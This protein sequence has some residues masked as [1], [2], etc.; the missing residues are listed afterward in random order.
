VVGLC[1]VT[2][3][4]LGDGLFD[5]S[6]FQARRGRFGVGSDSNVR[7]DAAGELCLLEYGQRLA[8]RARNV[9]ATEERPSTGRALFDAALGGGAQALG[10]GRVGLEPGNVADIVALDAGHPALVARGGDAL[11]DAWLFAACSGA[12]DAVWR[13]GRRVVA[14]GRHVRRETIE[15]RFRAALGRLLAC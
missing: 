9:L 2:E 1:P 12:I 11:L 10:S 3:A 13:G 8:R 7:I 6:T 5:A 14:G 4:N 15:G